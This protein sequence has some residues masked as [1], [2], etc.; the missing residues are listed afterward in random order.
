MDNPKSCSGFV[1]RDISETGWR[2]S[3]GLSRQ[4][5]MGWTYTNWVTLKVIKIDLIY[6][7]LVTIMEVIRILAAEN[8]YAYP[9]FLPGKNNFLVS[10][11]GC[12]NSDRLQCAL[13]QDG[14]PFLFWLLW[15][16]RQSPYCPSM[17]WSIPEAFKKN[18]S[19]NKFY[20]HLEERTT[21]LWAPHST[22]WDKWEVRE[23]NSHCMALLPG[24]TLQSLINPHST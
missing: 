2:F 4:M 22:L 16:P 15:Q 24:H 1:D 21:L 23:N 18:C 5:K 17:T 12:S 14:Y 10:N 7:Y 13:Y 8:C 9:H 19:S 6:S 3:M 20:L 11:S